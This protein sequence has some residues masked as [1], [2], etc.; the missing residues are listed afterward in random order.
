[1][2]NRYAERFVRAE[3]VQALSSLLDVARLPPTFLR[4][5]IATLLLLTTTLGAPVCEVMLNWWTPPPIDADEVS[6]PH[7]LARLL[8]HATIRIA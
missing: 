3:G 8:V 1:M 7:I 4:F 5:T 2:S 6:E